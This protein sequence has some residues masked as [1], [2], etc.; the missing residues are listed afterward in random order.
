MTVDPDQGIHILKVL[1]RSY[2]A[3]TKSTSRK[4][5]LRGYMNYILFTLSLTEGMLWNKPKFTSSYLLHISL[6]S[7]QS[8]HASIVR[9][10]PST[11]A[12]ESL[13]LPNDLSFCYACSLASKVISPIVTSNVLS[14]YFGRACGVGRHSGTQV[15][16]KHSTSTS[17]S[18]IFT[19]RGSSRQGRGV[20]T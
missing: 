16:R 7:A 1:H 8:G 3:D 6:D 20:L 19:F 18:W 15:L 12:Q 4:R 5:R 17:Y 10:N 14:D 11:S 9:S 2:C 13:P